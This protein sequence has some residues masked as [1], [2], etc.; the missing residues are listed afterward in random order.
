MNIIKDIKATLYKLRRKPKSI[1]EAPKP[2]P[3]P[4]K[5]KPVKQKR[6]QITTV[7]EGRTLTLSQIALFYK[8]EPH[9]VYARYRVGNRGKLLIRP[10]NRKQKPT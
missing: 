8:L 7:V 9:T 2:M 4:K 5:V 6:E 3:K 10:S 1:V